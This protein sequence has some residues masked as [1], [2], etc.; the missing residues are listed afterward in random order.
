MRHPPRKQQPPAA[1]EEA[2]ASESSGE[3]S[4]DDGPPLLDKGQLDQ[5]VAPIAL[6]PDALLSQVLIAAT[7]PLEVVQAERWAEKNKDL[8]G[9]DLEAAA[10]KQDWDDSIKA[11]AAVPDVLAMMSKDLGLDGE[12][13]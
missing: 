5:L 8:K 10:A 1:A 9:D 11:L 7:Y 13:W 2:P 12:A 6:Y 4:S 3:A